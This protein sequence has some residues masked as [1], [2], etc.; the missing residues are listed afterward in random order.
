MTAILLAIGGLC[1][2]GPEVVLDRPR[3]ELLV[4]RRFD[5][6]LQ[7]RVGVSNQTRPLR[8]LVRELAANQRVGVLIDR[9][10][11]PAA[12]VVVDIASKPLADALDEIA[13]QVGARAVVVANIVYIGPPSA[14]ATVAT[15]ARSKTDALRSAA[16]VSSIRQNEL[17]TRRLTSHWNDLDEPRTLFVETADR[18][19]L[20]VENPEAIPYDL[21]AGWTL[22][23]MTA[24]EA[25]SL[26][27][28]QF[29]LSFEWTG[30]GRAVRLVPAPKAA[31]VARYY[32]PQDPKYRAIRDRRK[33]AAT[34][35]ADW[36]A[37][38]AGIDASADGDTGRVLVHGTLAQHERLAELIAPPDK[39]DQF[40]PAGDVLPLRRRQFTLT[41]RETP[42]SA[43][44]AK[45]AESGIRFEYDAAALQ[46]AGIDLNRPLNVSVSDAG[47]QEFFEALFGPLGLKF[48]LGETTVMLEPK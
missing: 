36:T 1:A 12:I 10:V 38:V 24:S 17:A 20:T 48:H 8:P 15:L 28:I 11:D 26:L 46:Q 30:G 33:R 25:L 23:E 22:P 2:A 34:A 21:G 32:I 40:R 29:D 44:M 47:P 43:V 42:V 45:L 39:P 35:A 14:A 5:E 7:R 16:G 4:D 27:A 3:P 13:A 41:L 9:R 31:T 18:Y 6:A 19:G 37:L